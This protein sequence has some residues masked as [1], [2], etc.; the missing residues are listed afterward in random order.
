MFDKT[1]KTEFFV[2]RSPLLPFRELLAFSRDLRAPMVAH[3]ADENEALLGAIDSDLA[4]LRSRIKQ[5]VSRPEIL[6]SIL[7]A[8]PEMAKLISQV[9][10]GSKQQ[11]DERAELAIVRYLMRMVGRPTP[12]GT[13][14]GITLGFPGARTAFELESMDHYKRQSRLDFDLLHR[15]TGYVSSDQSIR[16]Q[17]TYHPNSS[18]YRVGSQWRYA[19]SRPRSH[20]RSYHLVA[21]ETSAYL[22]ATLAAA[23]RGASAA[24]LTKQLI[25]SQISSDEARAYVEQL[26]SSEILIPELVP[27]LTG[28]EPLDRLITSLHGHD[29]SDRALLR[30]LEQA[31]EL[32]LT[33]DR[34]PLGSA[35]PQYESVRDL[36]RIPPIDAEPSRVVQVD[37]EK[38]AV[39]MTLRSDILDE[40]IQGAYVL[41]TMAAPRTD[42][43]DNFRDAFAL[44]YGEREVPLVEALD[45]DMGIGVDPAMSSAG[46][47]AP[48]MDDIVFPDVEK[49]QS[50]SWDKRER[51]LQRKLYECVRQD[52][53]ELV[54]DSDDLEELKDGPNRSW[55]DAFS[56]TGSLAASSQDD[57]NSGRFTIFLRGMQG[58]SGARLMGRFCHLS[59][60]LAG[61]VRRHLRL[62]EALYPNVI[63]AEVVH[64][65]GGRLG[66]IAAR[67]MLRE[68][69]IP[70]LGRSSAPLQRQISIT[71]LTVQVVG[72]RII[73]RSAKLNREIMPRLSCAHLYSSPM[74]L[75]VYRF[76]CLLQDQNGGGLD[77]WDWGTFNSCPFLPR[78]RFRRVVLSRA[79]W[80]LRR[81]D[82]AAVFKETTAQRYQFVQRLREKL[83][84]P[85]FV[86]LAGF[87]DDLIFDLDNVLCVEALLDTC[88][89]KD[90]A[91]LLEMYP[92]PDE[93]CVFGPE[94]KFVSEFNIPFVRDSSARVTGPLVSVKG[95]RN[96]SIKRTFFPGSEWLYVKL[97]TGKATADQVLCE[98][99]DRLREKAAERIDSWFF[100]RYVD[101]HWHL[102]I[103][104]HGD[105]ENLARY[106]IPTLHEVAE[107]LS[108]SKKLWDM[109]FDA[110]EREIERYGGSD[111]I[112]LAEKIFHFDS[113]SVLAFLPFLDGE[114]GADMR[115]LW[116]LRSI[117]MLLTDLGLEAD[118]KTQFVKDMR[119]AYAHEFKVNAALRRQMAT[120]FRTRRNNIEAILR[121]DLPTGP[122]ME[123][124][125]GRSAAIRQAV[126]DFNV[127]KTAPLSCSW[128]SFVASVVHMHVNRILQSLQR[129]QEYVL[130]DFLNCFYAGREARRK[131]ERLSCAPSSFS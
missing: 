90:Y 38:P 112:L 131:S 107:T 28:P 68:H 12:F 15:L 46:D 17:L 105:E 6:E 98:V 9:L 79:R 52:A 103:R 124:F 91:V 67:P 3:D 63:F 47:P 130:Y 111:G 51:L 96:N 77:N 20:D 82:L 108:M 43:L 2:M 34:A 1:P 32:L 58:P 84:L 31:R 115:W 39:Q 35:S 81:E 122:I 40:L 24:A 44:R 41:R 119:D 76:L 65:P 113:E 50:V 129:N 99:I 106:V 4:L 57:L 53:Y 75:G 11:F 89:N 29:A 117:D 42:P 10:S 114:A 23:S 21:F 55:P 118:T 13:F 80:L 61:Y 14:S 27:T 72:N 74:I 109:K 36:F 54:L 16:S 70:Y 128:L 25:S 19:E 69:E 62:E 92:P 87:D 56:L 110:Y 45:E 116:T 73:L 37:M 97:Y 30:Q 93:L 120:K 101:P 102:R 59:E 127:N 85:R 8:S 88:K 66:N 86:Y 5:H 121:D 7:V 83:R 22:E 126:S 49:R 125:S 95:E 78:V 18:L 123:I 60:N 26:I 33:A 104:F 94:G 48:L 71:D 64:L 100:I